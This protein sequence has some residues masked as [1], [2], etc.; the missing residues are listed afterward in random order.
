MVNTGKWMVRG[1]I[2][3]PKI[4]REVN[5]KTYTIGD[6]MIR[7][8]YVASP[9]QSL[10][11]AMAYMQKCNIRHLPVVIGE[12]LA[13]LVSERD[14]KI[15]LSSDEAK[16]LCV[17]EIMRSE[18]FAVRQGTLLSEVAGE[19]ARRRLG[20]AIVISSNSEVIGIFTTTDA[21][22]ILAGRASYES[23]EDYLLSDEYEDF[24][25]YQARTS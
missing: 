6:H 11:D 24:A 2:L 10:A 19:M 5:L 21:L 25:H 20:S 7:F 8:P 23:I 18:V 16:G 13:G 12:K 9:E 15:A 14:L 1:P 4:Q 22:H 17:G 3:D